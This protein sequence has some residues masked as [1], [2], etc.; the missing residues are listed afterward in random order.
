MKKTIYKTISISLI[1]LSIIL[2][3]VSSYFLSVQAFSNAKSKTLHEAN[4]LK[5][6][7][8][9]NPNYLEENSIETNLRI[10]IVD[11][12]GEVI[13]D[14]IYEAENLE[15]H[16]NRPEIKEALASST[17]YAQRNSPTNNTKYIYYA[18]LLNNGNV[19]RLSYEY[20]SIYNIL[21]SQLSLIFLTIIIIL[22][23]SLYITNY[24]VNKIV[25]PIN[26][27]NLE[28]PL[29]NKAY[30]EL[31][32]LLLSIDR[33]NKIKKEFS[34]NV[35]HELKTPLTSISGYAEIM[36]NGIAKEEDHKIFSQ[37]IYDESQRLLQK[38]NNI[39]KISKLDEEKVGLDFSNVNYKSLI[40]SILDNLSGQINKNHI[41]LETNLE[42]ISGQAIESVMYDGIH[43]IIQN[44]IKY[45]KIHGIIK[46]TLQEINNNIYIRIKDSGI[47]IPQDDLD[48]IF[49]RFYRVDKSRSQIVEGSGLGLAISKHA[50]MLHNGKINVY[51]KI[52]EGTTFE[53]ILP[54]IMIN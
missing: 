33:H 40:L 8:D 18:V 14:N 7:L 30:P 5:I 54:K 19:L 2:F 38:I 24:H 47:G 49:E 36:A 34:A 43:N 39:I 31:Y 13:Y 53:I 41:T 22:L 48:R 3:F 15:N 20:N 10:T 11:S 29:Q 46:I 27:L 1:T 4:M 6:I 26:N 32:P 50:I 23:I 37:K 28:F 16:K 44:A 17:G 51:S 9:Q 21:Y 52:N 42:N 35:S 12:H 25:K 45:N